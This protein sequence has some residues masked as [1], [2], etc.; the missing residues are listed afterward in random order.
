MYVMNEGYIKLLMASTS[1]VSLQF[2][3]PEPV[4]TCSLFCLLYDD[5]SVTV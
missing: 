3:L 1:A 5:Q 2:P 4:V